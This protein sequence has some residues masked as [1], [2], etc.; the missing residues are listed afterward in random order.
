MVEQENI[1]LFKYENVMRLQ[2]YT[3]YNHQNDNE[4]LILNYR[5]KTKNKAKRKDENGKNHL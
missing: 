5:R 3:L 2:V 1:F 4:M